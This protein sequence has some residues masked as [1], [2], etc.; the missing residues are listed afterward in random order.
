[1]KIQIKTAS[2]ILIALIYVGLLMAVGVTQWPY[3]QYF[4]YIQGDYV[5][6]EFSPKKDNRDLWAPDV[7]NI[8]EILDEELFDKYWEILQLKNV[9]LPFPVHHP[10]L[11]PAPDLDYDKDKTSLGSFSQTGVGIRLV[12]YQNVS[13]L[14]FTPDKEVKFDLLMSKDLIFELPIFKNSILKKGAPSIWK[15]LFSKDLT[16]NGD[17]SYKLPSLF[18]YYKHEMEDLVYQLY[19]HE[20]RKKY[21]PEQFLSF[22]YYP[23]NN[24]GVIKVYESKD[25]VYEILYLLHGGVIYSF[26]L[27]TKKENSSVSFYRKWVLNHLAYK[28]SNATAFDELHAKFK[29]LPRSQRWD[30]TGIS[31]VYCSW[32]HRFEDRDFFKSMIQFVEQGP[33]LQYF[34][35]P[36]YE[37]SM[38][39]Y[40]KSFSRTATGKYE[41]PEI[42]LEREIELEKERQAE[43][44]IKQKELEEQMRQQDQ[45]QFKTGKDRIDYLLKKAKEDKNPEGTNSISID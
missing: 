36:L 27:K 25:L 29:G 3:Y 2:Y 28:E 21:F 26:K 14:S 40:G 34:V 41:D 44:L 19:L 33:H 15:D 7:F 11:L 39:F 22:Y 31:Y 23:H 43:E 8:D 32:S 13:Y 12:D 37:F 9:T 45:E 35:T 16:I 4:M 6:K 5:S 10:Y 42:K 18:G 20:M 17:K 1:M 24:V 30:K 38:H